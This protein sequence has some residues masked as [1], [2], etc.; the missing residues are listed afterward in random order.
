MTSIQ[1]SLRVECAFSVITVLSRVITPEDVG[2]SIVFTAT[3]NTGIYS[4]L[5]VDLQRSLIP[6]SLQPTNVFHQELLRQLADSG[7]PI[8]EKRFPYRIGLQDFGTVTLNL[9]LTVFPPSVL[10][11]VATLTDIVTHESALT[12]AL[13]PL[14][15]VNELG[16]VGKILRW[17]IGMVDALDH[18]QYAVPGPVRATPALQL[19]PETADAAAWVQ[20]RSRQLVGV[21]IRNADYRTMADELEQRILHKNRPLNLKTDRATTLL[22]KQGLV[23]ITEPGGDSRAFRRY[24]DLQ[25]IALSLNAFLEEYEFRRDEAPQLFDFALGKIAVWIQSPHTVFGGRSVGSEMAW[26]LLTDELGLER[27]LEVVLSDRRTARRLDW[28]RDVNVRFGRE[29]WLR[30]AFASEL[31][32][33]TPA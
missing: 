5:G 33:V 18:R 27:K 9:R 3:P 30:P 12:N 23:H 22:D 1:P 29:W 6:H 24:T 15:K 32:R 4:R 20:E 2:A 7:S 25:G 26:S 21:L 13:I 8:K 28:A 31:A 11:T 19:E 17:T 14:Q 16:P 10:Y